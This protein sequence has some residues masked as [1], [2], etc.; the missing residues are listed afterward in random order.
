MDR[1]Q[2]LNELE[3]RGAVNY[4]GCLY[5]IVPNPLDREQPAESFV[6]EAVNERGIKI[7]KGP[8][9]LEKWS[10]EQAREQAADRAFF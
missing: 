10:V 7:T 4:G 6:Y 2:F 1:E 5:R 3:E 8:G 9:P